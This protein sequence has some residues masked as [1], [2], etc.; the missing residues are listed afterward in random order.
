MSDILQGYNT[1]Q[2]SG[3]PENITA[4][5]V[6]GNK[7]AL[8]TYVQGG[9]FGVTPSGLK[10]GGRITEVTV[11]EFSWS[12]LPGTALSFRNAIRIQNVSASEIKL[13]Y[14]YDP[15]PAG[16]VGVKMLAGF[17]SYYDITADI[18]IYAKAAP[19]SGSITVVVEEIG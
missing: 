2:N 16:Y 18:K 11:D 14:D 9:T 3:D 19:G 7:R 12:A 4:T 8:D 6:A 10:N 13:N 1:R 5:N 15:L 17:E